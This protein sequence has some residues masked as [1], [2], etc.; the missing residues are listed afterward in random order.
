MIASSKSLM[1]TFV[2]ALVVSFL[3]WGSLSQNCGS[4]A[5]GALC[6][7]NNCYS[8]YGYC[9]VRNAWCVRVARAIL[10][11]LELVK[12]VAML[13]KTQFAQEYFAAI[14]TGIVGLQMSIA[15]RAIK[16]SAHQLHRLHHLHLQVHVGAALE[17]LYLNPHST[18]FFLMRIRSTLTR[19]SWLLLHTFPLLQPLE[20]AI[21]A[22]KKSQL[23][24]LKSLTKLLVIMSMDLSLNFIVCFPQIDLKLVSRHEN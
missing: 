11:H 6:S 4:Q 2:L 12:G 7:D 21:R 19:I 15:E 13:L 17:E 18:T 8:Q 20:T 24:L 22:R 9:G 3:V 23:S 5:G 16:V 10:A 1:A 14:S